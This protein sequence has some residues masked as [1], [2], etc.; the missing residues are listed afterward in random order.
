MAVLVF[1]ESGASIASDAGAA[2]EHS[3]VSRPAI[4][5]KMPRKGTPNVA[6]LSARLFAAYTIDRG[7]IRLAGCTLEPVPI[8]HVKGASHSGAA[9]AEV[10]LSPSTTSI[11]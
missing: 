3:G 6:E 4:A 7:S 5:T 8:V 1:R 11:A 9:V 2:T 10:R